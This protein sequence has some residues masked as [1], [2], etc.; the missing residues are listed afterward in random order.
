M[1][2][3]TNALAAVLAFSTLTAQA[4]GYPATLD[5]EIAAYCASFGDS[6]KVTALSRD[7][8]VPQGKM[9]AFANQMSGFGRDDNL[10]MIRLV[11]T[12]PKF[13]RLKPDVIGKYFEASCI[14]ASY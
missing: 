7:A 5:Q 10:S 4:G 8:H 6:A 14:Q 9:L 13:A 11:Y 2:M 3:K 1:N 12:N